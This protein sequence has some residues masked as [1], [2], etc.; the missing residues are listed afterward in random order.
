[1]ESGGLY[2][3]V[4]KHF[5]NFRLVKAAYPINTKPGWKTAQIAETPKIREVQGTRATRPETHDSM[6]GMTHLK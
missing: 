5:D 3:V 2:R 1:M 4:K 6:L